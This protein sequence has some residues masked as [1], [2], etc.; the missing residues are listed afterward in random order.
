MSIDEFRNSFRLLFVRRSEGKAGSRWLVSFH[1]SIGASNKFKLEIY[2]K[3]PGQVFGHN[4][5][6]RPL[7]CILEI[8]LKMGVLFSRA[9]PTKKLPS[10]DELPN[11]KNFPGCAWDVWGKDDQLGTVNL[12][13]EEV[14][15]TAA[16]EEIR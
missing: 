6:P 10:Y 12:L 15:K 8:Q 13:T 4:P 7:L 9:Q 5:L 11:F 2:K 1:H 16:S 3:Q 14:V